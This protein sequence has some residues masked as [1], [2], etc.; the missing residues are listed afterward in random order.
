MNVSRSELLARG[1][2]RYL[3][4]PH[5]AVGDETDIFEEYMLDSL[6]MV[7]VLSDIESVAGVRLEFSGRSSG[8]TTSSATV[9]TLANQLD[10]VPP[11]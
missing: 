8:I 11:Q 2:E 5:G 1:F 7:T 9:A 6:D 10:I 4:L 3:R